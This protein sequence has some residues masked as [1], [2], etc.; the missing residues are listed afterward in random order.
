MKQLTEQQITTTALQATAKA[1]VKHLIRNNQK[2]DCWS[3]KGRG[4]ATL[5]C[6]IAIDILDFNPFTLKSDL[7][8]HTHWLQMDP[9][10]EPTQPHITRLKIIINPTLN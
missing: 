8:N 10:Q 4:K 9:Y 7:S 3:I 2:I 1:T 6:D 5:D